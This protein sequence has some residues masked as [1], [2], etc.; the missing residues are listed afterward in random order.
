MIINKRKYLK[1]LED[2]QILALYKK[3]S[4]SLCIDELFHRYAHLLYGVILKY[5][6]DKDVAADLLMELFGKLPQ[7]I[8]KHEIVQLRHWLHTVARNEALQYL[9]SNKKVPKVTFDAISQDVIQNKGHDTIT[10]DHL[11]LEQQ[12]VALEKLI[13]LLKPQQAQCIRLFFLEQLSYE[14]IM[15]QTQ[16]SFKEVKSHLQNGKRNLRILMEQNQ[17]HESK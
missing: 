5:T 15:S 8:L 3:E 9:R 12:L 11:Q 6:Q 7:L 16:L 13:P 4:W 1:E 17:Q 2:S 10:E 14:E